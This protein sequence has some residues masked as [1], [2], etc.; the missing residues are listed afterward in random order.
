MNFV[1]VRKRLPED[2][3]LKISTE[4]FPAPDSEQDRVFFRI[5]IN[6][7]TELIWI[8]LV[9]FVTIDNKVIHTST[10]T[11]PPELERS[12]LHIGRSLETT[13][14]NSEIEF[15]KSSVNCWTA[16]LIGPLTKKQDRCNGCTYRK[17][18]SFSISSKTPLS[19]Q[20]RRRDNTTNVDY[21]QDLIRQSLERVNTRNRISVYSVHDLRTRTRLCKRTMWISLRKPVFPLSRVLSKSYNHKLLVNT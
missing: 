5:T 19:L 13:L 15:Q 9:T 2:I 18:T 1:Q 10:R 14:L 3:A 21:I 8:Y 4:Y 11:Y 12:L 17:F 6:Q 7:T 16:G 20:D